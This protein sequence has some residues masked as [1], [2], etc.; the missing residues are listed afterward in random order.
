[1]VEGLLRKAITME[2]QYTTT[3]TLLQYFTDSTPVV[4]GKFDN[5]QVVIA[6]ENQGDQ[7]S[8]EYSK[9]YSLITEYLETKKIF[10]MFAMSKSMAI[11]NIE[12]FN[13]NLLV[14]IKNLKYKNIIEKCM[15]DVSDSDTRISQYK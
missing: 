13:T 2:S 11:P 5:N 14:I 7:G 3:A 8:K 1:M 10:P 6:K 12:T 9:S 15:L 4:E